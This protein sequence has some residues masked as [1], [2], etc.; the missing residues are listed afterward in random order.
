MNLQVKAVRLHKVGG[1]NAL[2]IERLDLA[3]PDKGMA[4]VRHHAIG[5]NFIDTYHR[6]G[7]YP[8]PLPTSLGAEAAGVIEAVGEGV[9]LKVGD[10]VVYFAAGLGAYSEASNLPA[11]RLI[12]LPDEIDFETAAAVALKG[13]TVA[14]LA[15]HVYKLKAGDTCLFHAAAGGV[16][17]LFGQ[18][19]KA[20]G[21]NA[22]GTVGS[23]NKI[24]MAQRLGYKHV[25][26]YRKENVVKLVREITESRGVPVV[27]DGVGKDTFD[28]SLDCLAR[29]GMMVSFGNA[30]GP[31]DPLILQRLA[32]KGS[33]YVT[34]PSLMDYVVET[35]EMVSL[36]NEVFMHLQ[37]DKLKVEIGQR[38]PLSK[39]SKVHEDLEAGITTGASIVIPD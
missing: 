29:R 32:L 34:R 22:I 17:S 14:C 4:T 20:I 28:V 35:T 37:N 1:P 16:G 38:Y 23:A 2:Q 33:L 26:N 36:M 30:S 5:V 24:E 11:S 19:T 10:R 15:G 39:I 21:V 6:S 25:V 3:P 7:L 9:E 27:Y 18:W 31:P 12:P 13:A 8:L